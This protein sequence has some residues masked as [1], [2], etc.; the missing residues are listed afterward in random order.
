LLETT[1]YFLLELGHLNSTTSRTASQRSL[2]KI[3]TTGNCELCKPFLRTGIWSA[4]DRPQ[5]GIFSCQ[6]F[7]HRN[8]LSFKVFY[9][10]LKSHNLFILLLLN[11][12]GF[13]QLLW[14]VRFSIFHSISCLILS[15]IKLFHFWNIF[16]GVSCLSHGFG[17]GA[18]VGRL[19]YSFDRSDL[20]FI[21]IF[22]IFKYILELCIIWRFFYG[23]WGVDHF[24]LWRLDLG[25]WLIIFIIISNQRSYK[26]F[27]DVLYKLFLLLVS[28]NDLFGVLYLTD[29]VHYSFCLM[30]GPD[31]RVRVDA[32][33]LA[34][35]WFKF[36]KSIAVFSDLFFLN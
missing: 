30:I 4:F 10:L 8:W 23:L 9:L 36:I 3:T 27:S 7:P 32:W 25:L 16:C 21:Q 18:L 1:L 34:S 11:Y 29:L 24:F 26:A 5:L 31:I 2:V 12:F 14:W 6:L 33:Y 19:F 20:F 28:N 13:K 15:P 35:I 17:F 22:I